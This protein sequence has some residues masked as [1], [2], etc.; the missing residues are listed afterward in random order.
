MGINNSEFDVISYIP[1]RLMP[2]DILD[3]ILADRDNFSFSQDRKSP[4]L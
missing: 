4:A 2:R 1:E 3:W